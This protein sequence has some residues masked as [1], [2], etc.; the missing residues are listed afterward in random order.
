MSAL[1]SWKLT[2]RRL[3]WRGRS[4]RWIARQTGV[5]VGMVEAALFARVPT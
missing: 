5:P 3:F 2:A 4:V 1:P